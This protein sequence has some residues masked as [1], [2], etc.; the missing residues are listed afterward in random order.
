LLIRLSAWSRVYFTSS[1]ADIQVDYDDF[2]IMESDAGSSE[3][4]SEALESLRQKTEIIQG[5]ADRILDKLNAASASGS[6]DVEE[7]E[8]ARRLLEQ[9]TLK[10]ALGDLGK[11]PKEHKVQY[12]PLVFQFVRSSFTKVLGYSICPTARR[13]PF[14]GK[15]LYCA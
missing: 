2:S 6:I 5:L 1:K 12:R 9:L 10:S 15:Q 11:D 3:T 14:A 4:A 7:V 13:W 8:N